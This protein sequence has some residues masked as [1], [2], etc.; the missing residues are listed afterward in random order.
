MDSLGDLVILSN[1]THI[2]GNLMTA[3]V[4]QHGRLRQSGVFMG[5]PM[6]RLQTAA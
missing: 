6:E 4:E 3:K 1:G 5:T 2:L